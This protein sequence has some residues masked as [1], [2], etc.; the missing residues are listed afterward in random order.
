M[1]IG[2]DLLVGYMLP[3]PSQPLYS[4]HSAYGKLHWNETH[5]M[6]TNS[7]QKLMKHILL[8]LIYIMFPK[9]TA[10]NMK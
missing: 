8:E 10:I 7:N 5:D 6:R 2:S 3:S 9:V 4:S 1:H